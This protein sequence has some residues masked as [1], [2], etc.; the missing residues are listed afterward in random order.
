MKRMYLL[1]AVV[2]V[3]F[4]CVVAASAPEKRSRADGKPVIFINTNLAD[5]KGIPLFNID[6]MVASNGGYADF[7]QIARD[8]G[9][10]VRHGALSSTSAD[11]LETIDV[12]ILA[13]PGFS[14][15]EEDKQ[16][17]T[18]FIKG[19]GSL[20][21]MV[22]P[23]SGFKNLDLSNLGSL[24]SGYGITFGPSSFSNLVGYL[25]GDTP[26]AGPDAAAEIAS[27]FGRVALTLDQAKAKKAAVLSNG[28]VL[29]AYS[30]DTSMLGSGKV[31]V[32][33][34]FTIPYHYDVPKENDV[35]HLLDNEAFVT[36]FLRWFKGSPDLAALKVKVQGGPFAAG[37]TATVKVKTK[38][39][40]TSDSV[41]TTV[42]ITLYS[43]DGAAPAEEIK[44][45]KTV[46]LPAVSAGK[47]KTIKAVITFPAF[48]SAGQYYITAQID[49][50]VTSGDTDTGNNL[51]QSIV[52]TLN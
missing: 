14:L 42:S 49:P 24:L 3:V 20:L 34:D 11:F 17:I 36:N 19:G 33:G 50:K 46:A 9:Y 40:G 4:C 21:V 7:M 43:F 12:L 47:A 23:Q 28:K 8:L 6:N 38:N 30:I 31:L 15:L 29:A 27:P 22:Y 41:A 48:L 10:E 32:L 35:I 1:I 13:I 5:T 45:L 18:D 44:I 52:F 16:A 26:F 39:L 51:K 2:L 37:G 25:E